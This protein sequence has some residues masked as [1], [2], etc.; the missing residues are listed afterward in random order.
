MIA[1]MAPVIEAQELTKQFPRATGL[2]R[3]G[4][5]PA[6]TAVQGVDL[7][8]EAGELFGLIGPNGAGKTTLVKLLC[9]L[10]LPTSGSA[11]IAGHDLSQDRAIK[12][13]VGLVVTDERSFYWR[14]SGRR[15]LHFFAALQGLTGREAAERV[16]A[17]LGQVDMLTAADE[18]FSTYSTG[19]RQRLAIARALLHRPRVLFMDEP[20][21]SLDPGAT[22]RLHNLV[23]TLVAEQ[24]VTVFLTTHDLAE[25]ETLCSRV[26]VMHHGRIRVS[27][28]PDELR[29]T[30]RPG[31][32]YTLVLDRAPE[33]QGVLARLVEGV[34]VEQESDGRVQLRFHTN[35]TPGSLN[36]ALDLLR[37]EQRVI[38]HV[39]ST[40]PSL[41]DVFAHYTEEP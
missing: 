28:P 12:A 30:L 2:L 23:R 35:G 14:L 15:N 36:A 10:I 33:A 19:M 13:A 27:A 34:R 20:T 1:G 5:R 26:A 18:Q 7:C 22:R 25:A 39:S 37:G 38:Y 40:V 8:V 9:T 4:R 41:E 29:R 21:R 17:V 11:R 24:G 32:D 16:E 31:E 6:I 3:L